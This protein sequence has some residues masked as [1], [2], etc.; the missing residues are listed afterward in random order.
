MATTREPA[1]SRTG[2]RA[3]R[4]RRMSKPERITNRIPNTDDLTLERHQMLQPGDKAPLFSLPDA[5]MEIVILDEFRGKKNLILYF[6]PKDDTPGCTMEAL[7]FTD[8]QPEFE[9]LETEI[10]GISKDTCVS[11]GS[12]RD[13]YGIN[14]RLLADTEGEACEA[15][16]VW[17]EKVRHDKKRMGILRSTFVLDKEGTVR[18]A[19]YDIKPKA[20]AARILELVRE[21]Q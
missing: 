1:V 10:L 2:L 15:Y 18:H 13:K 17:R 5:D 11:H 4:V 21:I 14:V 8:L 20:H 7:E 12:F 9:A 16:G 6:Y 19:L 3:D